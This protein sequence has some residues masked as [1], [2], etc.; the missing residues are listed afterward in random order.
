MKTLK[1][2]HALANQATPV[3]M[4]GPLDVSKRVLVGLWTKVN[5]RP[6]KALAAPL[7]IFVCG[8][9]SLS[10]ISQLFTDGLHVGGLGNTALSL[11]GLAG[12]GRIWINSGKNTSFTQFRFFERRKRQKALRF[13]REGQVDKLKALHFKHWDWTIFES[14]SK[15]K[16][17]DLP[18]SPMTV[19][20][21]AEQWDVVRWLISQ[22]ASLSHPIGVTNLMHE[23]FQDAA[24]YQYSNKPRPPTT[25][26][27]KLVTRAPQ[28]IFIQAI[29]SLELQPD[30]K[31]TPFFI[32]V[33]LLRRAVYLQDTQDSIALF[34]KL[35]HHFSN[36]F[37]DEVL[38]EHQ[39]SEH[40]LREHLQNL[41]QMMDS[42]YQGVASIREKE[43]LQ[44][45]VP[46]LLEEK[47]RHV[48]KHL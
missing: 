43:Q 13:C 5:T 33:N 46:S 10:S 34:Q 24:T 25:N 2:L 48:K 14:W 42:L 12:W 41:D 6:V 21:H 17:D 40:T 45:N 9:D 37:L 16:K 35:R 11:M 44:D 20:F 18:I 29:E 32:M 30:I 38:S 3:W 4:V 19:A 31:N 47:P 26:W 39:N 27:D 8:A 15:A 7:G 22:K 36:Q 1:H 23:L 28:D